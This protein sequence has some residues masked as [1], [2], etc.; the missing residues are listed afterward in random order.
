LESGKK[1]GISSIF[2]SKPSANELETSRQNVDLLQNDL[3]YATFIL[4]V[5]TNKLFEND[6]EEFRKRKA[7]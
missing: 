5:M 6:I 4:N 2:N 1:S 3:D 7:L